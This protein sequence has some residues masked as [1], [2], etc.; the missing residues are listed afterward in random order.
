[1][2]G[3]NLTVRRLRWREP[4]PQR[5]AARH[6]LELALETGGNAS[7]LKP[8]AIL[9]VRRIAT[10]FPDLERLSHVLDAEIRNA[11]RP[12]RG[13]VPANA[14]AVLFADR[15]ELLACLARDWCAAD[16]GIGWWWPVL[17]PQD[18]F[19]AL[20]RRWLADAAAIPAALTRLEVAGLVTPFLRKFVRADLDTLWRNVVQT[21]G[22]AELERTWSSMN[23]TNDTVGTDANSQ[24]APWR[25]WV[26]PAPSLSASAT[27]LLVTAVLLERAPAKVRSHSF[28]RAVAAWV[29]SNDRQRAHPLDAP[30]VT[31]PSD[32]D[33]VVPPARTK[34]A[35][36]PSGPDRVTAQPPPSDAERRPPD[37]GEDAGSPR[38]G[39][40][41]ARPP[42]A[43]VQAT[44]P[45]PIFSNGSSH[46]RNPEDRDEI[47]L[48]ATPSGESEETIL[49][50]AAPKQ[51]RIAS[52]WGGV[53]YLVNLAITAGLYPDFTTPDRPGLALPLWD[54]LAL[55]GER[56]I[57]EKFNDDPLPGFLARLSCRAA[58]DRPGAEF[59]PPTG[60]SLD[61]WVERVCD[62]FQERVRRS[63]GPGNVRDFCDL[64]LK[65][66]S[67]IEASSTRVDAHF[68]LAAHPIELR[69]AGLVRD[70]GWIPAGG[71]AI[72]FHYD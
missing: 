5:L 6:R 60:E 4:G 42:V 43:H 46:D 39:S 24:A 29:E 61:H 10:S 41:E 35:R 47:G 69:L 57:G 64:L 68:S 32:G 20:V 18:D 31:S 63:I 51:D 53:F 14:N 23:L 37:A 65:H 1:M 55:I 71:R 49:L 21:F 19:T 8:E 70:P 3:H 27:R 22:L 16:L 13:I 40:S 50:P 62:D 30:N 56:M 25:A 36:K 45:E 66:S 59:E 44:T 2:S 34:N 17:F 33:A 11:A 48:H 12:A 26:T 72:Y 28:A 54:F 9:C 15:A 52:E 7:S 38:A 67:K 58:E